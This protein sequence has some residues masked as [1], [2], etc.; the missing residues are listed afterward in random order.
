MKSSCWAHPVWWQQ[1]T[2]NTTMQQYITVFVLQFFHYMMSHHH[3]PQHS[4]N[5]VTFSEFPLKP[6]EESTEDLWR[7]GGVKW[8]TQPGFTANTSFQVTVL[9]FDCILRWVSHRDLDPG[10]EAKGWCHFQGHLEL[11]SL[12]VFFSYFIF[13]SGSFHVWTCG[14]CQRW[15]VNGVWAEGVTQSPPI[16]WC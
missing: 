3:R 4:N 16:G 10:S 2:H 11:L 15:S 8:W 14:R 13:K 7:C 6:V 12:F 5:W 9:L 1:S